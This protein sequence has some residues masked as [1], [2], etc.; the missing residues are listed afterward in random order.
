MTPEK[1]IASCAFV[2]LETTRSGRLQQIGALAGGQTLRRTVRSSA[3]S[4]VEELDAFVLRSGAAFVTGHNL[5][6][7]DWRV[8]RATAPQAR[9]LSLPVIDTLLLS[10]LAFPENPYHRLVKDY[11]LVRDAVNDPVADARLAQQLFKDECAALARHAIGGKADVLSLY[12]FCFAAGII[13]AQDV[14]QS[15]P[16]LPSGRDG[17]QHRPTRAAGA[18]EE[19]DSLPTAGLVRTFDVLGARPI[20]SAAAQDIFARIAADRVCRT[21]VRDAFAAERSSAAI[22]YCAAWLPVAGGNSVLP[23]WVRHQFPEVVQL[24]KRLRDIP[25]PSPDCRYCREVHDPVAQLQRHFGFSQFR[26]DPPAADGTR[27]D[28][29]LL[30]ARS[31]N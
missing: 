19:R 24:L 22:A 29:K 28:V 21:A 26:P 16:D 1:L 8:V 9:L 7:H 2:D 25:C 30:F 11:K 4:A 17:L 10:P 12:R 23:P 27:S 13:S 20:T 15:G 6:Q 18:T 5:L 14:R 31:R 3:A